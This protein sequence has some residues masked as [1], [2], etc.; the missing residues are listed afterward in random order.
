MIDILGPIS[1]FDRWH[2]KLFRVAITQKAI[3]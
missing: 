2:P 1:F 3:F